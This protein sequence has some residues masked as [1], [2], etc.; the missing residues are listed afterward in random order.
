MRHTI[1]GHGFNV[2]QVRESIMNEH[3]FRD[4]SHAGQLL[5]RVLQSH[6]DAHPL[7]LGLPRGGVPVAWEIAHALDTDM[8]V[9]VVRKLGIPWQPE[10]AFGAIGE[11]GISIID[12][13]V[14]ASVGLSDSDIDAISQR[15]GIELNLRVAL[16][17]GRQPMADVKQREVVIVDDG[18]ATGSTMLAAI[19]VLRRLGARKI[20]VA[21]PVASIQ[22]AQTI[23]RKVD[24]FICLHTPEDFRAVALYYDNFEQETD[25]HVRS[26]LAGYGAREVHVPVI[27]STGKEITLPGSLTLPSNARGIVIFAHGSGSSRFSSRNVHVARMLQKVGLG[28]L[29]FDLLTDDEAADRQNVFDINLLAT[30]LERAID[31]LKSH[32]QWASLPLALF[33]ASTGAGA[34]LVAAAR[35]PGDVSAVVSRGGRPDLAGTALPLVQA[36]T[37]LVVG[38]SDHEVI[39]LNELAM[40]RLQ[41]PHELKI[42]PG[43]THLFEEPG[44]LDAA[45]ELAARWFLDHLPVRLV[46]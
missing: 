36:P 20:V 35:R 44:T 2:T 29:L 33:G 45:A 28:T 18:I 40:Q 31:Y 23:A 46:V 14:C 34:A 25:E 39:G 12:R 6:R 11:N 5:G 7:I 4:R 3:N 17:R 41:C 27:D 8:D 30:R 16:F 38:G 32:S 19:A 22:A 37:L 21:A 26:L 15:E 10:Y 24:E 1:S 42:V 13:D 43:A 9:L